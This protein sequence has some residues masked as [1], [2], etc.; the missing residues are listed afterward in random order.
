[1]TD[2]DT[3]LDRLL[4]GEPVAWLVRRVRDRLETG[5]PLTGTVT[6]PGAPRSS[7]ARWN[8]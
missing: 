3:R 7:G 5:R 2:T 8:G 4:G 1:M 6:L